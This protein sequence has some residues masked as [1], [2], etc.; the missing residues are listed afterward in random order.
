M[1]WIDLLITTHDFDTS[2]LLQIPKVIQVSP[3]FSDEDAKKIEFFVK[4]MQNPLSKDDILSKIQLSVESNFKLNHSNHILPIFEKSKE[5]LDYHHATLDGYIESAIDREKQSSTYIGKGI[6]L[7]H[8][9][10]EKY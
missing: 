9:T 7:P 3:L 4:A 10:P 8:G 2:Q 1:K 5:I 6:A